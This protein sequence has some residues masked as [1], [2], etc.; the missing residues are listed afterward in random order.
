MHYETPRPKLRVW[1]ED[2]KS[3]VLWAGF[4]IIIVLPAIA[5]LWLFVVAAWVYIMANLG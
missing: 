1:W 4:I 3:D 2:F 5:A